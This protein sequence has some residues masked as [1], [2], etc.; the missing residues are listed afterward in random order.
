M[1]DIPGRSGEDLHVS[2]LAKATV[3]SSSLVE[4]ENISVS[5]TWN[6]SVT[7]GNKLH[8]GLLPHVG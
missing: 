4:A 3:A 2:V 5:D 8:P 1:F 7:P 6:L